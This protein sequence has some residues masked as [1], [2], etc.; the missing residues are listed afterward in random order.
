VSNLSVRAVPSTANDNL[1]NLP[2][3]VGGLER[4]FLDV[5]EYSSLGVLLCVFVHDIWCAATPC[6]AKMCS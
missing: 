1:P 4:L 2:L 3:H 6:K 5:F